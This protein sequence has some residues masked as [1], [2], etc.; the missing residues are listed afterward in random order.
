MLENELNEA[1][2]GNFR[3]VLLL[4]EAGAGKSRL[5][6]ELLVRH[7]EVTGL[8][9]QAY[10]LAASAAFG[11]WTEALDPFLQ[12]LPDDEVVDL[13]GGLLDDLASLFHRVA[14]VRG[15][16]PDRDPPLPRLLQGLAGLLGNVLRRTPLVV[17]LD[18]VHLADAS[19]WEAVRYFAR[20]LDD[21]RLLAIATARP[22]ELTCHEVA[23]PVLFELEQDALLTRLEIG[24]LARPPLRE[25][26][27]AM[28]AQPAP[29]ALVDWVCE[30]SQGNPLFAI[31][32]LRA[33]IDEGG[34]LSAPHLRR[35]PEGLT[36]RV[37]SE[38]RRL[39]TAPKEMLELMA[40]V[41]RPI[42]LGDL[43]ALAGAPL[44]EVGPVLAELV[45]ARVVI[46]DERA[47]ELRY[48]VQH[49]LVRD[50]IY[51]ATG[52]AR[53]RLLHRQAA[54]SL[55]QT[56]HLAEAALHFARSAERGD[57]EAVE[58]LL[59]AM[60]QA[61]RREAYR[62]AL[63]LQAEAQ[64]VRAPRRTVWTRGRRARAGRSALADILSCECREDEPRHNT[65]ARRDHRRAAAARAGV[66]SA[67]LVDRIRNSVIG[68]DAVLDG[69]F[70]P[71]RMVYADATASGRSCRSSR[72]SS[73]TR[74]CRCTPT[75]TRRH[76]RR[77]D[78]PPRSA[79]RPVA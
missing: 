52:G 71:C 9:A 12:P 13:C 73:A 67:A 30:R 4:G 44:E 28:I 29:R 78:S 62:E 51:Q 53:R 54:R 19:S 35:L 33:L 42:S 5:G 60:R 6:R 1:E 64:T 45:G 74:C 2:E 61:E 17:L 65:C 63:Q 37:V 50:V 11:L 48:E 58:V 25:L 47:G 7:P 24:A 14:L 10:P 39:D 20:H 79:R 23:A 21:A 26:T 70:G 69:P 16:V 57:S 46:E 27:E 55:R 34:D 68:D 59:D 66:R 56:G 49:P 72:T 8:V 75:P 43:T 40:V 41:G 76:R 31:G 18:D 38:L 15:S 32:L 22:A 3:L 36:E 77:D